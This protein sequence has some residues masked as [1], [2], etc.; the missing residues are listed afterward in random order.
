MQ[1]EVKIV[2]IV[3]V[4]AGNSEKT[5]GMMEGIGIGVGDVGG[6]YGVLGYFHRGSLDYV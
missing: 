2:T 6:V 4:E 5:F 1:Q 3:K